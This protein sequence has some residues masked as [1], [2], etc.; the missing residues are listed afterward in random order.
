MNIGFDAKRLFNNKS[1]LGNYSRT[2]LNDLLI[3]APQHQYHLYASSIRIPQDKSLFWNHSSVHRYIYSQAFAA[4]WRKCGIVARLAEDEI[5]IFHGLSHEIPYGL[6]KKNIKSVVTIHDVMY[7]ILP[8]TY[9]V[10]DRYLYDIKFKHSC[11]HADSI[12]AISENTKNDI[13]TYFSIPSE[14]ITVIKQAC[15]SLYYE[16]GC[17][18]NPTVHQQ[19]EQTFNLPAEFILCV[20]TIEERK[21]IAL[22]L[23]SYT[24]LP[25]SYRLP[26]VC[27]GQATKYQQKMQR[28]AAELKVDANIIWINQLT[29][30]EHLIAFYQKASMLIYPSLYE[31]FGLPVAEALL[32]KLPVITSTTSS[33]PEAGGTHT[34]YTNPHDA[35]ELSSLI[36]RLLDDADLQHTMRERGYDYAMREFNPQVQAK[37][38]M[39]LYA[40]TLSL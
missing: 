11:R 39:A 30:I 37:K 10:G 36:Q 16:L 7:K 5:D 28:L 3:V 27:I 32:C 23:K 6:K 20:G 38:M 21:N 13:C 34:L 33:M 2:L 12:V 18:Q 14:R 25:A 17:I 1:G 40:Q 35:D 4:W 15:S 9:A 24:L 22:I 8:H 19:I 29:N 31:G 26:L